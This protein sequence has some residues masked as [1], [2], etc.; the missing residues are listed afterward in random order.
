MTW[1]H[2]H[3]TEFLYANQ[4]DA[5]RF[6]AVLRRHFRWV[7]PCPSEDD[8]L[9]ITFMERDTDGFDLERKMPAILAT[10]EGILPHDIE[11]VSAWEGEIA[12]MPR[13]RIW[14]VRGRNPDEADL[15]ARDGSLADDNLHGSSDH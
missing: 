9:W 8:I 11:I 1:R 5:E 7:H 3:V 10:L 4:G 6:L 12:A 2:T 15:Q 13:R 14:S